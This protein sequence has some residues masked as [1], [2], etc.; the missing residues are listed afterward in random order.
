MAVTTVQCTSLSNLMSRIAAAG[1]GA[2]VVN[3][4]P[5][6]AVTV[7]NSK[8]N[9]IRFSKYS[10]GNYIRVFTVSLGT[11]SGAAYTVAITLQTY[12]GT[13]DPF[14]SCELYYDHDAG[15][16]AVFYLSSG[17][18]RTFFYHGK[19]SNGHFIPLSWPI[20]RTIST[21]LTVAC[22]SWKTRTEAA[23]R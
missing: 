1:F 16:F 20:A 21:R 4:D 8:Y 6:Y 22:Y 2:V 3:S 13:S 11:W 18:Y 15:W 9:A 12:S 17:G 7:D 19:L 14:G 10:S 5:N 23:T